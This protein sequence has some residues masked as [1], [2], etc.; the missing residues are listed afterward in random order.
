MTEE[1]DPLCVPQLFA[2]LKAAITA[3]PTRFSMSWWRAE[4][5]DLHF[6]EL[7]DD[8]PTTCNTV[9]CLAG[10][11]VHLAGDAALKIIRDDV[12]ACNRFPEVAADVMRASAPWFDSRMLVCGD[13]EY[14]TFHTSN[15]HALKWL[16]GMVELEKQ[17]EVKP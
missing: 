15:E 6:Y 5:R 3:E 8:E 1:K 14:G 16:D 10:W 13:T 11:T 7:E 12:E 4:V 2:K 17:H 9:M